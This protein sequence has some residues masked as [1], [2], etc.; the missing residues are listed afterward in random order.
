M[1]R[2]PK[3]HEQ[4]IDVVTQLL[5]RRLP[6]TNAMVENLVSIEL[7][8]INTKHPDFHDAHLVG[9]LNKS[10]QDPMFKPKP[11]EQVQM[12]DQQQQQQ[13]INGQ[14]LKT[15]K[16]AGYFKSFISNDGESVNHLVN[17]TN[18]KDEPSS[19]SQPGTVKKLSS[20][21]NAIG[22]PMKPVNLLPEFVSIFKICFYLLVTNASFFTAKCIK[23]AEV[24]GQGGTRLSCN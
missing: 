8:Y 15:T 5:R 12:P 22:S 2:F 11:V 16:Q 1:L 20:A 21:V 4:I 19:T 17:N 3:L 24:V 23:H 18:G 6:P 9:E 7:A 10:K 13:Q 14:N